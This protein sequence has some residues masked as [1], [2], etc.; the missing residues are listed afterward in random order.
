MYARISLS[1]DPAEHCASV[2]QL[3]SAAFKFEERKINLQLNSALNSKAKK[4]LK[5]DRRSLADSRWLLDRR[6]DPG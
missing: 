2:G 6:P 1:A 3:A 4:S 5:S